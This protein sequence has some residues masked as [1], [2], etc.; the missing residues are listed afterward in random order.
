[1]WNYWW[2]QYEDVESKSGSLLSKRP[3][4]RLIWDPASDSILVANASPSQL[5]EIERLIK[6]YDQPQPDDAA[7]ERVTKPVKI[8]YSRASTIVTSLKEVFRDLLSSKDKEFDSKDGQK[9]GSGSSGVTVLR[10]GLGGNSD[11]STKK[12]APVKVGFQGALSLGADDVSNIVLV[13][14]QQ[15]VFELVEMMIKQLD[16]EAAPK[17]TVQ[18]HRVMGNIRA[19]SLQKALD[20]AVGKAWLGN[21][22]EPTGTTAEGQQ[23][24]DGDRDRGRDRDRGDRRN[25]GRDND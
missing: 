4:L 14:A 16:E 15:E 22:P 5:A 19:E 25:R 21:R 10:F 13:S 8:Q 12:T 18:V 11:N 7:T 6:E 20:E 17:T 24:G 2:D 23:Q 3:K 9:S 1:V